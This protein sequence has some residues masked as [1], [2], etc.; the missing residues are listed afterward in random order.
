MEETCHDKKDV[1]TQRN[2]DKF[3]C[4][5]QNGQAGCCARQRKGMMRPWVGHIAILNEHEQ[6]V[7]WG[8]IKNSESMEEMRPHLLKLNARCECLGSETKVVCVDN[9][10]TVRNKLQET[11]PNAKTYLDLFH[12]LVRWDEIFNDKKCNDCFKFRA[13]VSRALLLASDDECKRQKQ[14]LI[15]KLQ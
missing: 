1:G 12:W 7:W 14:I 8:M 10:C 13:F 15:N 6:C 11:F 9:C 3:G 2:H 5:L 4:K